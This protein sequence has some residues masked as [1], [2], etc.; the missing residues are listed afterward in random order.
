MN[1]KEVDPKSPEGKKI[2][3]DTDKMM[4]DMDDMFQTMG[5]KLE[6]WFK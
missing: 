5:D 4:D 6:D 3:K 2:L 1:G